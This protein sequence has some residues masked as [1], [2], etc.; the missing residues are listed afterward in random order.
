MKTKHL[1]SFYGLFFSLL[2]LILMTACGPKRPHANVDNETETETE[3]DEWNVNGGN[4]DQSIMDGWTFEM[5]AEFYLADELNHDYSHV[6][7]EERDWLTPDS[8]ARLTHGHVQVNIPVQQQDTKPRFGVTYRQLDTG[9]TIT[10]SGAPSGQPT[11]YGD[12]LQAIGEATFQFK[13]ALYDYH[14]ESYTAYVQ[15]RGKGLYTL[16]RM[17][18]SRDPDTR[19]WRDHSNP[20]WYP[21]IISV[22]PQGDSLVISRGM[23]A[24]EIFVPEQ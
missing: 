15:S 4:S 5:A 22:Y 21:V 20:A 19:E 16:Y 7:R 18:G 3:E 23:R 2:S 8:L 6:V 11:R 10:F 17:E 12:T 24:L 9:G 14:T 13:D 1:L